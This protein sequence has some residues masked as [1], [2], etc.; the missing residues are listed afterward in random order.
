[1]SLPSHSSRARTL[2]GISSSLQLCLLATALFSVPC[3]LFAILDTLF[4]PLIPYFQHL[5]D[6]FAEIG[7]G[8]SQ[9]DPAVSLP[10]ERL[11]ANIPFRPWRVPLC[12]GYLRY[13]LSYHR[14]V[15]LFQ[16]NA[17]APGA[18]F[19]ANARG[20]LPHRSLISATW[21]VSISSDRDG[22]TGSF[23]AK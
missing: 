21:R 2:P 6:S 11:V 10:T 17:S 8:I 20:S 1:M 4:A 12:L 5:T 22:A 14:C 23:I 15:T 18:Y 9:A 13:L 16:R 3:S 19:P 7:G